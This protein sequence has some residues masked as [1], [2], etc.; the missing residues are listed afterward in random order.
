MTGYAMIRECM[1]EENLLLRKES[2]QAEVGQF[3]RSLVALRYSY[4]R[5]KIS[6]MKQR[7]MGRMLQLY[8][9]NGLLADYIAGDL[10]LSGLIL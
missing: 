1:T 7:K 4:R 5:F 3:K 2:S 9:T 8:T 6:N 10:N